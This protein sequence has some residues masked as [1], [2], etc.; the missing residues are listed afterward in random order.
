MS[1]SFFKRVV[2][3]A[4]VLVA[5]LF[6]MRSNVLAFITSSLTVSLNLDENSGL[7]ATDRSGNS[8]NGTVTGTPTWSGGSIT[9]DGSDDKITIADTNALDAATHSYEVWFTMPSSSDWSTVSSQYPRLHKILDTLNLVSPKKTSV[10]P[11]T[12][13]TE[14][15][16]AP[17]APT[18]P[19]QTMQTPEPKKSGGIWGWVKQ[20]FK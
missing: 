13:P 14:P 9:F 18:K 5:V 11:S 17:T 4:A 3:I 1:T 6:Q 10:Q 7:T 2:F 20:W 19:A 8:H 12:V 16:K 15:T